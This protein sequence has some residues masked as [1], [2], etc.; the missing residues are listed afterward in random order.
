M[1]CEHR[2]DHPSTQPARD[3]ALDA[4]LVDDL[5]PPHLTDG[6]VGAVERPEAALARAG[7]R[8]AV[9]VADPACA[10]VGH[11][12][13]DPVGVAPGHVD[14]E[15][16]ERRGRCGPD[17]LLLGEAEGR[18]QGL[19]DSVTRLVGVRVSRVQ[20]AA[21]S[22]QGGQCAALGRRRRHA[23][24]GFEEERMMHDEQVGAPARGLVGDRLRGVDRQQHLL[25][26]RVRVAGDQADGIPRVGC[27]GRVPRVEQSHHVPHHADASGP[28]HDRRLVVRAEMT[29]G[30]A[31]VH[32]RALICLSRVAHR[33]AGRG[34]ESRTL[35]GQSEMA[36]TCR[37]C[38][39]GSRG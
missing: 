14:D 22:V 12:R 36:R 15:L 5:E 11:R 28:G 26:G 18:G 10:G 33:R 29:A 20:G 25:D 31:A 16:V 24:D 30:P 27:G 37:A 23:V 34:E 3:D 1:G 35:D 38:Q 9:V 32:E 8:R 21:G 13:P 4:Q 17:R 39:D 19:G 2:P 6:R 7:E